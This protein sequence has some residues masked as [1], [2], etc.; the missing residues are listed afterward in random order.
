MYPLFTDDKAGVL[1]RRIFK[2]RNLVF[3]ALAAGLVALIISQQSVLDR[4]IDKNSELKEDISAVQQR[5]EELNEEKSILGSDEY[6]EQQAR[7]KLGYVKNDE[8]VFIKEE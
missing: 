6:I 8:T 1:M 4:N 7:E 3:M 2:L 5:I